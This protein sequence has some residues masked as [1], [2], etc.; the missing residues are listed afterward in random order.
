[1][2]SGILLPGPMESP[3]QGS[4]GFKGLN[5]GRFQVQGSDCSW[6]VWSGAGG[7]APQLHDQRCS[8]TL[9]Q[10]LRFWF[11]GSESEVSQFRV[12]G[13]R[14]WAG[15]WFGVGAGLVREA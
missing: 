14:V 5:F 11:Q 2:F 1:M 7:V 13:C 15:R 12:P 8:K 4:I 6:C 9:V 3:L 10:I